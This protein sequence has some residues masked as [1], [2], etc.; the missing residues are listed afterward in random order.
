MRLYYGLVMAFLFTTPAFSQVIQDSF[1]GDNV[2]QNNTYQNNNYGRPAKVVR[3]V[4]KTSNRTVYNTYNTYVETPAPAPQVT[5]IEPPPVTVVQPP[6]A[7]I[8]QPR[9]Y[10]MV[11][12]PPVVVAPVYTYAV[13]VYPGTPYYGY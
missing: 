9:P 4:V 7:V 5:V 10:Y 6:P 12:S 2:I 3:K 11:P 8:V 13:P 1:F